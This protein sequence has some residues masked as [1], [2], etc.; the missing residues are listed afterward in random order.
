M[1]ALDLHRAR[2]FVE[3]VRLGSVS[4]AADALGY[5]QSATSQQLSTLERDLGLTLV[6]RGRRPL[7]PTPA[8][9][10]LLPEIELLLARAAAAQATVDDLRGLRRGRVRVVAFAS[11]LASVL[12]PVL[13]AFAAD[14]PGVAVS[15]TEA[16]TAPAVAAL[17]A[18]AADLA[19]IHLMPGQELADA[20]GLTRTPLGTDD[21]CVVLPAGHRL[22]GRSGVPLAALAGEPL[23]APRAGGPAGAFRSLVDRLFADAGAAPQIAYEIDD[24]P[25][26]QAF[27][28]AGL[29]AVLMHRLTLGDAHAGVVIRPLATAAGDRRVE[30]VSVRARRVPAARTLADALARRGLRR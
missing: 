30:V 29:G 26:A 16:E 11:A 28:A 2:T 19:L 20:D 22:S 3:V 10:E 6:D 24:L 12:P 1:S 9:E 4:A 7:R 14:H 27:A 13:A 8:G 15:A 5:T 21:L 18:G 23:V 25:A 17:H